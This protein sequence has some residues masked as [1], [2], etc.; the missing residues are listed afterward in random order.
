MKVGNSTSILELASE[1]LVRHSSSMRRFAAT[2]IFL[3]AQVFFLPAAWAELNI[4]T[5]DIGILY[6]N[7]YKTNEAEE[8]LKARMETAK[9]QMDEMNAS[10]EAEIETYKALLEEAQNPVLSEEAHRKAENDAHLQME[11]IRQMQ[12]DVRMFQQ[13]TQNQLTTQQ[14]TQRQFMLEE[15]KTV[16]LELANQKG[17]DLVLDT[18]PAITVSLPSVL[19]ANPTW[20]ATKD[21]LAILNAD[22]PIPA[23]VTP[24]E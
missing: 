6:V 17:V 12:Q 5:V 20:D 10:L 2:S 7:Y 11:K 19:F 22:A 4:M 8:K 15:I 18:S 9:G 21:V 24:A 23:E 1:A 14:N 16:V 13:S 3:A